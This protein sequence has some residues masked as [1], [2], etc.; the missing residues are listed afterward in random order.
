MF[1]HETGPTNRH[2]QRHDSSHFK[3]FYRIPEYSDRKYGPPPQVVPNIPVRRNGNGPF[4]WIPTEISGVFGIMESTQR[5]HLSHQSTAR[6]VEGGRSVLKR[7]DNGTEMINKLLGNISSSRYDYSLT[8]LSS[9]RLIWDFMKKKKKRNDSFFPVQTM[10]SL[11]NLRMKSLT[12]S[13]V[14]WSVMPHY[15]SALD[16]CMIH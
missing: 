13:K 8:I 12:Y 4:H 1:S 15:V 6:G 14:N 16:Y 2:D 3:F 11:W 5:N 9:K 7:N 10:L